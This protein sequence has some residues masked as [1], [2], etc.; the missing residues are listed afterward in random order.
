LGR[1]LDPERAAALEARAG[2]MLE[3]GELVREL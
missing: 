3:A 2:R 1:F